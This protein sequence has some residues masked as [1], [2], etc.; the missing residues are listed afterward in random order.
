MD[1][2][3]LSRV[4]ISYFI[5][6]LFPLANK[7][8][9]RCSILIFIEARFV[10]PPEDPKLNSDDEKKASSATLRR[11]FDIHSGLF[12]LRQNATGRTSPLL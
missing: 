11:D 10:T 6:G 5:L 8:L 7:Q 2:T 1:L 4:M 9:A 3:T 12:H